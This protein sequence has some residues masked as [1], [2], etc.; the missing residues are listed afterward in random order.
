MSL[1]QR[2]IEKPRAVAATLSD[3]LATL[4]DVRVLKLH[5]DLLREDPGIH[6]MLTSK[7]L[8]MG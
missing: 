5:I 7:S 1:F 3:S 6:R 2:L 8:I 4:V